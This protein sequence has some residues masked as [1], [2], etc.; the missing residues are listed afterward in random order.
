MAIDVLRLCGGQKEAKVE[1]DVP[2]TFPRPPLYKTFQGP[3]IFEGSKE[4]ATFEDLNFFLYD[5]DQNA[6]FCQTKIW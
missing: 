4:K 2:I 3:S 6:S 1:R 5:I